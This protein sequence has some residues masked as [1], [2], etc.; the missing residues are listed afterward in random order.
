MSKVSKFDRGQF[1]ALDGEGLTARTKHRYVLMASSEGRTLA[2]LHGLRSPAC[3]EYLLRQGEDYPNAILVGFGLSYDVN[4]I[5]GDV[6]KRR[7]QRLYGGE[8][9]K[10]AGAT[11]QYQQRKCLLLRRRPAEWVKRAD[12]SW[13]CLTPW[14]TWWDTHAFFQSKFVTAMEKYFG[15]QY[16]GLERIRKE[17]ARRAT[18]RAQ[19]FAQI[20]AY[21][22]EECRMLAELMGLLRHY[23]M[24]AGIRVRRWDGAGAVAAAVLEREGIRR[25]LSRVNPIGPMAQ[26]EQ[27]A[28]HAYAGG[29]AE[30]LRYGHAPRTLIHH[31]DLNSAY[32]SAMLDLP[33][34]NTGR[35]LHE[36]RPQA[37]DSFSVYRLR[38]KFRRNAILYPFFWRAPNGTI[39]YP[40]EGEG[41]YWAPEVRA[42][43]WALSAGLLRG[44][45]EILERWTYD[46]IEL[47][48]PFAFVREMYDR[49]AE[50]KAAKLGAEKVLKLAINSLYG[51]T[52]QHVGFA[53]GRPRFHQLEWAGWITSLTRARLYEAIAP[54]AGRSGIMLATDGIYSLEPLPLNVGK[55]LGAWDY[56]THEGL[57]V[58][59]SGVYW[60]DNAPDA[61]HEK[62]WSQQ[63]CRGFDMGS[64]DRARIV[65]A[66]GKGQERYRAR[67]TRFIGMGS[68]LANRNLWRYWRR[69]RT[70]PRD[71]SLHMYGTKRAD[72]HGTNPALGLVRTRAAMHQSYFILGALSAPYHLPW[73]P[74]ALEEA[75]IDGVKE[76]EALAEAND[77]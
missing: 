72:Y 36:D 70:V 38:W 21:C 50:W 39:F 53:L 24:E 11:V 25:H 41:W 59:Q 4:M 76:W 40:S 45:V 55:G 5:L 3:M 15:Q 6:D 60:L 27:A 49:R 14:V 64:L 75:T 61:E 54:T 52:A 66:W 18:F 22:L 32:P 12:G 65:R 42:A 44:S 71:L 69:W 57:T 31:Y 8:R 35:W 1:I 2:N 20:K 63:F 26:V 62:R 19:D 9:I 77:T 58:V 43:E 13:K 47:V 10:V 67:L 17:K 73:S 37:D 48:K 7:L 56:T 51:K 29:R 33:A 30:V 23:L 34:L 28:Q 68:A 74:G 16:A 46:P